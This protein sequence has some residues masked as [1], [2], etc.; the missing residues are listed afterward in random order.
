MNKDVKILC[1]DDTPINIMLFEINFG[2]DYT[3]LS[4]GSGYAGLDVLERN[5][6]IS[7][8]FSD[9]KMPVMNG[10]EFIELAK[11][12]FPEKKCFLITGFEITDEIQSALDSGLILN[13]FRKPFNIKEID[14][15]IR[16][17]MGQ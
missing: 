6:D 3:V 2:E 7:I 11:A 17:S 13:C 8:I 10:I 14:E 9:M 12:K 16:D 4:A 15:A 5:P 1:V